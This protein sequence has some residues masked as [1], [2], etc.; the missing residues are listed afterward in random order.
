MRFK[1]R[2]EL[3]RKIS[4]IIWGTDTRDAAIIAENIVQFLESQVD[5]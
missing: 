2:K 5:P 1:D 3:R 4:A